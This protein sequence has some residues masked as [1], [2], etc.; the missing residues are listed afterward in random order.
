MY[1]SDSHVSVRQTFR[2]F[3]LEFVS[4]Q[5][6]ALLSR[7]LSEVSPEG[8]P[9]NGQINYVRGMFVCRGDAIS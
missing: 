6:E 7:I 9:G 8:Q 2:N 3:H 1:K 5:L 4:F